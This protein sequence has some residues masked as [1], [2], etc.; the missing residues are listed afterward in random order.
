S[1]TYNIDQELDYPHS[2]IIIPLANGNTFPQS[3]VSAEAS[4]DDGVAKVFWRIKLG[5]PEGIGD[6]DLTTGWGTSD[7]TNDM[8]GIIDVDGSPR[9]YPFQ[10]NTPKGDG[11]FTIYTQTY[12]VNGKLQKVATTRTYYQ[13]ASNDPHIQVKSPTNLSQTFTGAMKVVVRA[14]GG[15]NY[16]VNSLKYR[17]TSDKP[18]DSGLKDATITVGN[19][20]DATIDINTATYTSASVHDI[21]VEIYCVNEKG[22]SSSVTTLN[23]KADNTA[24]TTLNISSPDA[25]SGLNGLAVISGAVQDDWSGID[26][27][28][29]GYFASMTDAIMNSTYNTK[30]KLDAA[31]ADKT[32]GKWSKVSAPTAAWSY[33]FDTTKITSTQANPYNLYVAAVDKVGNVKYTSRSFFIDQDLDIPGSCVNIPTALSITFPGSTA[34][35]EATDDDGLLRLHYY[36]TNGA[37]P[38]VCDPT[39]GWGSGG[40][41]SDDLYGTIPIP[42]SPKSYPWSIT[43]PTGQGDYTIYLKS[44]DKNG[45][46][47]NTTTTRAYSQYSSQIPTVNIL[48]LS[49]SDTYS[50]QVDLTFDAYGG[51]NYKVTQIEY[52]IYS[53]HNY[54]LTWDV[55]D[56]TDAKIVTEDLTFDSTLYTDADCHTITIEV[57]CTNDKS[58][59]ATSNVSTFSIKADNTP[60]TIAITS[61]DASSDLNGSA[62][63]TGT[64]TDDWSGVKAIYIGYFENMGD[65]TMD[66]D[67]ATEA[68]LSA[69]TSATPTLNKWT[70]FSPTAAW[71]YSYVTT[72]IGNDSSYPLYV[73]A[74]DTEGNVSYTSR[75]FDVDQESD[76]PSINILAPLDGSTVTPQSAV[77]GNAIDDDGIRYVYIYIV[78]SG[79][80]TYDNPPDD[81][82]SWD[83]VQSNDVSGCIIDL[84]ASN[85]PINYP[86]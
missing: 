26:A 55:I 46:M 48:G 37:A 49:A 9:S 27:L 61:P 33:S 82:T 80:A 59:A 20:V 57:K 36:I 75:T 52:R 54:D 60:P 23:L 24:P 74:V 45:V 51:A 42:G 58:P 76:R 7:P 56:V 16:N 43:T 29:F 71:S 64:S 12:D 17:I 34:N 5:D 50:G 47:Q 11:K 2:K 4:D 22:V 78:K 69:D 79:H 67:Y 73:A 68:D 14:S 21:K 65:T 18:F 39:N 81:Y 1:R 63:I 40:D 41:G 28:Y 70:K 25:G 53:A 13:Y 30:A 72:V 35:G 31:V 10:L 83:N 3:V 62:N 85:T 77:T 84:T 86:W 66:S 32:L 8:S 38:G 44:V 15:A 6:P 19:I